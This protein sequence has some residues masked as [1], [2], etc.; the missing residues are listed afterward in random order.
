MTDTT[1]PSGLDAMASM[2]QSVD[3]ANP[4]AEQQQQT[5]QE[6]T[7]AQDAEA[8][9]S[10]WGM[11]MY[12]VGGFACMIAPE[13]KPI[14]TEERCYKWGQAAHAVAKKYKLESPKKMPELMLLSST[15]TFLV[16]TF[17]MV[18]EKLRE[19]REGKAP[20]SW[21]AKFG[22]WWRTRKTRRDVAD[23][24]DPQKASEPGANNGRQQ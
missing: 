9:A 7:Q 4:S 16:P 19:A 13:L 10:E 1:Q 21:L 12:T 18:R 22:L 5:Q 11:L 15:L 2:T 17:F 23:M 20:E 3:A 6:A 14:Y 24:A 8:S